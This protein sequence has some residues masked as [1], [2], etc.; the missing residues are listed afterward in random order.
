MKRRMAFLLAALMLLGMT[1]GAYAELADGVYAGEGT[2]FGGTVSVEIVVENGTVT[3]ANVIGDS[4]TEAIGGAALGDLAEQI[5]AAQSSEIDGVS[6]ATFTSTGVKD[7]AAAAFAQAAGE[8]PEA[9]EAVLADGEYTA[10]EYGFNMGWSDKIVVT[11]K[12]GAIES[13]AFGE[14]CGDTPPDA[15]HR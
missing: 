12:D 4:E 3:A 2:G 7:A 14:D 11:I 8:T 9:V 13:I 6:G 15:G 1:C 5:V 10:E